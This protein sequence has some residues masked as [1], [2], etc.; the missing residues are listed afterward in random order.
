MLQAC[1]LRL[2]WGAKVLACPAPEPDALE[3]LESER[4]ALLR[5]INGLERQL[6]QLRCVAAPPP[7]PP[8]VAEAPPA[9]PDALPQADREAFRNRDLAAMQGCWELDSEYRTRDRRTGRITQW[10]DWNIC[11]D[12]DGRGRE[13]MRSNRN[14]TCEGRVTATFDPSGSF[15][16]REP[17]NLRC[18]GGFYIYRRVVTCRIDDAGRALCD[19]FQPETGSRGPA[20]LRRSEARR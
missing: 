14:D 9:P 1:A 2:P 5:Q 18:T 7:A 12:A 11:L 20:Q 6:A 16:V 19:T 3:V 8:V 4:A 13:W 15:V 10:S 17:A